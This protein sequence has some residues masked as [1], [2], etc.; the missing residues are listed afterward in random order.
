MVDRLPLTY[1]VPLTLRDRPTISAG[2]AARC[3]PP[4]VFY[5]TGAA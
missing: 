5:D 1:L 2:L 4:L 3:S